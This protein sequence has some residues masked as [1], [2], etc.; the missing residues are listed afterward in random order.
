[1]DNVRVRANGHIAHCKKLLAQL[2]VQP[3]YVKGL[4]LVRDAQALA[5]QSI[6]LANELLRREPIEGGTNGNTE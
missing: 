1:M 5:G 4:P 3:N 6:E 2:E